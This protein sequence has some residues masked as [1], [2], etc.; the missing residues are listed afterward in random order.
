MSSVLNHSKAKGT[1]KLVLLGI[2]N[3]AGDGGAWPT[4]ATLARY[5]NATERS[6]QRAIGELVRLGELSVER[7]AGG[8]AF[9]KDWERPNRYDVLVRCP[10]TCDGTVNH[11][12]RSYP[13]PTQ[14]ELAV[15][16]VPESDPVTQAS[17][18]DAGVTT[19]PDTDVT[20]N[21]PTNP[22]LTLVKNSHQTAREAAA[23]PEVR[24][25]ALAAARAG[26]KG[27]S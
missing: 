16:V 1:A 4:V 19:P 2:A 7:Q 6:V 3:H 26:L 14:L 5:A 25:A 17:P 15:P 10:I 9:L 13:Q 18:P 20:H 12:L 23:S 8:L 27:G 24:Q 22:S 21:R 11:R